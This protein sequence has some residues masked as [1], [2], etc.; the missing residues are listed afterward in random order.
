M[1]FG[2]QAKG[3]L[4]ARGGSARRNWRVSTHVETTADRAG[5]TQWGYSV[6]R[7]AGHGPTA[8]SSRVR[9]S[10]QPGQGTTELGFP[11][12]ASG[13]MQGEAAR[14]AGEPP[15]QGEEPPAEGLG[16]CQLLAQTDAGGPAGPGCG[17]SPAPPSQAAL[18]AKRP[19]R[20]DKGL[21]NRLSERWEVS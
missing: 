9:N 3:K 17:P 10:L 13:K 14:R 11:G 2:S 21:R 20:T 16:G 12:P 6:V 5:A 15:G 8:Q 1:G 18:A 19:E 7:R 4:T